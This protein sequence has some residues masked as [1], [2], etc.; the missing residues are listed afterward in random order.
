MLLGDL[1]ARFDDESVATEAILS[2]GDLHLL[3]ALRER[4]DVDGLQLG[5]LAANAVERYTAEA[6]DEE[7]ITLM[8]ALARSEDPGLTW[9]KRAL[10]HVTRGAD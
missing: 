1:L 8:G 9:L 6:S 10:L 3:T 7:W 2:L 5:T 4:A